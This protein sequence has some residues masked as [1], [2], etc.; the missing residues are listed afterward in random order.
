MKLTP[1]HIQELEERSIAVDENGFGFDYRNQA[2]IE[3]GFYTRCGHPD[4]M[5]CD[6]Y[7]RIHEG[8]RALDRA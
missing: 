6:C 7:G 8:E 3:S 5:Q 2:W 1:T 4:A